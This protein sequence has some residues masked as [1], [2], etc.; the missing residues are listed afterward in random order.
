M[1]YFVYMLQLRDGHLYVGITD[2]LGRRLEEHREGRGSRT[3]RIAKVAALLHFE[4]H[5]C[6][7]SAERREHQLKGWTRAK[8][9]ALAGRHLATLKGLAKRHKP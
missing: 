9:M 1:S 6:R 3:T 5:S 4:E 2:N 7:L 8:K